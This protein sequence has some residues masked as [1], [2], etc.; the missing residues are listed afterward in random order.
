MLFNISFWHANRKLSWSSGTNYSHNFS[1]VK[2]ADSL[3]CR[4]THSNKKISRTPLVIDIEKAYLKLST[5]NQ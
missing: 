4:A 3:S 5:R 2:N 1:T